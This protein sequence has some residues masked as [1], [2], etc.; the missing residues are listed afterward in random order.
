MLLAVLLVFVHLRPVSG[1][2]IN[3]TIDDQL[4]DSV[5]GLQVCTVYRPDFLN[6]DIILNL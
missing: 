4:G 2:L 3:R 5:T 6:A 1:G